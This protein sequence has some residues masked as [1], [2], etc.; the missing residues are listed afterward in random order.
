M[1]FIS[2][3][4]ALAAVPLAL[5]AP[6]S[7]DTIPG[8]QQCTPENA[9][10]RK[11]WSNFTV[12]E[13]QDYVDALWCL[14][15]KPSV[16]PRDQ[17]PGVL[18]RLDDFVA[19]HMN[20]TVVIH[21]DGVLLPW[22]RHFVWLW[23]NALREE[24]GYKGTV[25]YW[26]WLLNSD[27]YSNA[28]FNTAD[29]AASLS[30]SGD[31]AY[32]PSVQANRD[33]SSL[34]LAPGNGGGCVLDGPFKNW[35]VHM[36]PFSFDQVFAY[37]PLPDNLFAYNPRCLMR[38]LQPAMLQYYINQSVIDGMLAAPTVGAF[39][40]FLDPS[41]ASVLGAHGA[42]HNSVGPAMQDVFS[43]PQDPV[44]MLH[45]GQIDRLWT[46]WQYTGDWQAEGRVTALNGTAM[47]NNPPGEPLIN[48]D[49]VIEFGPLDQPRRIAELMDVTKGRYCYKY[50]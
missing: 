26:D 29:P 18:D 11:E 37:A 44:F 48:L 14:R 24:C 4:A 41:D 45:H 31:G 25:P 20:Y 30:L 47:Y 23:E 32:D 12:A 10:V 40:N 35:T 43:S 36:G 21:R 7:P 33:P 49:T 5:A 2:S 9:L 1:R 16:L 46:Q 22:H 8:D 6:V 19:T 15:S 50:E 39:Y 34:A 3:L 38:N 42:G 28:I 13:Q 17:F 27:M